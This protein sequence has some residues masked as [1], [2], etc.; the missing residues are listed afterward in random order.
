M[1]YNET[2]FRSCSADNSSDTDTFYFSQENGQVGQPETVEVP[3]TIVGPNYFFSDA[4]DG[5][6]CENG[7]AFGINVSHG[8]GLPPSLNQPPPPLYVEP[9]S[10]A[11]G[12]LTPPVIGNQPS[13][14][15]LRVRANVRD[16]V[17]CALTLFGIFALVR[18]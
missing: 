10:N 3:L 7:M 17:C 11:D 9:P 4:Y 18:L 13:G 14:V 5:V 2:T 8:V 16:V 1:T 6:Q 15:G 12:S